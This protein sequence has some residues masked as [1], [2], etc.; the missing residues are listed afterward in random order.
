MSRC[1]AEDDL[2]APALSICMMHLWTLYYQA[3]AAAGS[4]EPLYGDIQA[5]HSCIRSASR[6]LE[7]F[8]YSGHMLQVQ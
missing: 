2:A 4:L 7:R 1:R 5:R 6:L 3:G 8:G